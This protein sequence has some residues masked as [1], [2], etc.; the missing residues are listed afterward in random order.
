MRTILTVALGASL[1]V[2]AWAFILEKPEG[3]QFEP[4]HTQEMRAEQQVHQGTFGEVGS[5]DLRGSR[6]RIDHEGGDWAADETLMSV[7]D[8]ARDTLVDAERSLQDEEKSRG[9]PFWI[10]GV[11]GVGVGAVFALKWYADKNVP[12]VPHRKPTRW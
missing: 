12:E 5:V 3:A 4:E 2:P 1:F 8:P 7:Q 10:L 11:A 6:A 9:F